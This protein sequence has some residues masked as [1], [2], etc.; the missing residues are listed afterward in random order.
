MVFPGKGMGWKEFFRELR[1]EWKNDRVSEVAGALTF[2]S[3]LAMFPFLLFLVSLAGIIID[4]GQAQSLIDQLSQV[5]PPQVT[6]ILGDRLRA[7]TEGE[8]PGLLTFGFVGAVWATSSGVVALMRALN[9]VYGVKEGRPFWKV[10]LLAVGMAL[11]TALIALLAAGTA[12][13]VP[14]IAQRIGGPLS[15]VLI[16]CRL[17]IAGALMMLL[18]ALL[19]FVLP[20]VKQKFKFITPGSVLGVALWLLGSWAFSLYV[21][22]FGK[23]EVSYGALG[24]VIVMLL[25]MYL[26]SQ[27]L[28]LGAEIN[29]ILEH[30]SPEGKA[31]GKKDPD[32]P[33]P[34][35]TKTEAESKGRLRRPTLAH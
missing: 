10:R 14:A 32:T 11:L 23:Y 8:S 30:K 3:I 20:D 31:P 4:P 34:R 1:T 2:F 33:G 18:W 21:T 26:S 6:Q 25:W 12:I 9:M 5:A 35:Q 7:L 28:L 17:P 24:G 22:H 27:V 29:S 16:W 15:T 13:V 19:Y